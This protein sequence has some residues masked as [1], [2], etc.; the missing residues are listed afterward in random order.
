MF[1]NERIYYINFSAIR[2]TLKL[3]SA[4]NFIKIGKKF[5]AIDSASG[6]PLLALNFV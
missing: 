6:V 5:F 4:N 1:S 3:G 2:A